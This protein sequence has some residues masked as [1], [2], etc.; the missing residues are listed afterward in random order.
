MALFGSDFSVTLTLARSVE[1][2]FRDGV[3]PILLS[4]RM[5]KEVSERKT[6]LAGLAFRLASLP[7]GVCGGSI[8]R[9]DSIENVGVHDW[10]VMEELVY[11]YF[12]AIN[13]PEL[14]ITSLRMHFLN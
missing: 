2:G 13:S 8:S 4:R 3:L 10:D 5:Q 14:H 12:A 1:L 6:F 9:H 7:E 11:C